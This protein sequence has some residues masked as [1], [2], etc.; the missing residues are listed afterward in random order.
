MTRFL[1]LDKAAQ[2]T[3]FKTFLKGIQK[4]VRF[5]TPSSAGSRKSSRRSPD[6][7]SAP[8]VARRDDVKGS[9]QVSRSQIHSIVP[10]HHR[11]D[12]HWT[13]RHIPSA[14]VSL[15]DCA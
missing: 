5:L 1:P 4:P 10:F 13:V 14:N 2:R 6:S 3:V 9:S 11:G 8:G 15:A 12:S 7:K